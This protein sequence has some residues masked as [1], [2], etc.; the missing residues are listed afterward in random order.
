M[1]TQY[2]DNLRITEMNTNNYFLGG[3]PAVRVVTVGTVDMNEVKAV[4]LESI[5]N[6]K[7]YGLFYIASSEVYSSYL[8][9]F[10]RISDS[11]QIY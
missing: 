2:V 10:Q 3:H 6:G 1:D 9:I 7:I 4:G 8:P 5:V 11:F